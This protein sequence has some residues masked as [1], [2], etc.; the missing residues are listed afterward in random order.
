M[1]SSFFST[2][3]RKAAVTSILWPVTLSCIAV[4]FELFTLDLHLSHSRSSTLIRGRNAH[5]LAILGH[6]AAR[7]RNTFTGQQLR[8]TAVAQWRL[9]IFFFDQLLDLGAD[10]GG[11]S[12]RTVRPS[13]R[14]GGEQSPQPSA[15]STWL[16][17]K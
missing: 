11:R 10:G 7:D 9:G 6:R 5:R 8:D 14:V 15:P 16:E 13:T 4:S 17:K 12:A 3:P 1:R 2:Y